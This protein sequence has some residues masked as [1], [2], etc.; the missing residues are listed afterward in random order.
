MFAA[1]QQKQIEYSLLNISGKGV[2]M[3]MKWV[4]LLYRIATEF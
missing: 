2:V 4:I 3:L 1:I